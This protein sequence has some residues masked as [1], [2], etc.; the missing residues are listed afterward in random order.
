MYLEKSKEKFDESSSKLQICQERIAKEEKDQKDRLRLIQQ[1]EQENVSSQET[2]ENIKQKIDSTNRRK[3][4][5]DIHCSDLLTEMVL[6]REELAEQ[7]EKLSNQQEE[8]ARIYERQDALADG[9][10]E[11]SIQSAKRSNM[12]Q[13]EKKRISLQKEYD[14]LTKELSSIEFELSRS[15]KELSHLVDQQQSRLAY[16]PV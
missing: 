2:V 8:L 15:K 5:A 7:Q 6:L 14:N 9:Q 1:M 13:L 16:Y 12:S 11:L 4:K 10:L 3:E